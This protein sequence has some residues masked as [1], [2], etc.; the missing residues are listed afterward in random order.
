MRDMDDLFDRS[1]TGDNPYEENLVRRFEFADLYTFAQNKATS[2]YDWFYYKEGYS[3]DFVWKALDELNVPAGGMVLDPFCG[4]GTTLLAAKQKGYESKG[5]DI[6]PLGVFVSRVKLRD[7]DLPALEDSVRWLGGLRF[8]KPKTKLVDIRFLDMRKVYTPYARDDIA[9]FWENIMALKDEKIRDFLLLGLISIVGQASNT[10]KD[11]GVLRIVKKHHV[12]PVKHLLK[13]KL[14]RMI[15][16][17]RES[18]PSEASWSAEVGDAR[19]IPI[20]GETVDAVITSPPYLNFVDYTKVYALELSLLVSSANDMEAYRRMSLRSHVA[21]EYEGGVPNEIED[22]LKRVTVI[23]SGRDK[24]PTVVESYLT[25][26][27]LNLREVARSL[28]SGGCAAYV[29][30]NATLPG[31]SV[32]VDLMLAEMGER[33]GLKADGI[34]VGNVRWAAV[35]DIRKERPARESAVVLRKP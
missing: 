29:V 2:V 23:D 26:M 7:Y 5:F 32:D 22:I 34:W 25:D 20:E 14:K 9:F 28:R 18:E 3:R 35:H 17:L 13:T 19:N 15:K 12:P 31:V 24:V 6:L 21:A 10:M 30:G 4:T 27:Y 16:D 8:Q 1:L 33:L 11:G